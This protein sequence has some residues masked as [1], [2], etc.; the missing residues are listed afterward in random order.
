MA[1]DGAITM[2]RILRFSVGLLVN[3]FIIYILV[4]VFAFGFSFAYD[5]FASNSC[6]SKA[7]TRVVAVTVLPDSSIKDVCETLDEAGVVKN[8]YAL[9]VRIRLSSQASKIRPGTYEI[10]PS[11]TNDEIITVITGGELSEDELTNKASG[12]TDTEATTEA[13]AD[14]TET[15]TERTSSD[16]SEE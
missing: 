8:A 7:D 16:E 12:S 14:T 3:V 4:R 13:T 6:K 11:Y 2:K 10:A 9:M 15:T 5:V 1:V